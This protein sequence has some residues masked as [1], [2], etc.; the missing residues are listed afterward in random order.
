MHNEYNL[1]IRIT[2]DGFSLYLLE[3]N[4]KVL[5]SKKVEAPLFSLSTSEIENIFKQEK[6]IILSDYSQIQI[7]VE[8]NTYTTVPAALFI[9]SESD[10]YFHFEHADDKDKIVLFNRIPASDII[11]IFSLPLTLNKALT[12][13]FPETTPDH[14]IT[15]FL[16]E[17]IKERR[18]SIHVWIGKTSVDIILYKDNRINLINNYS[19]TSNEDIIYYILFLAET[20][21]FDTETAQFILYQD[22]NRKEVS[23]LLSAYVKNC[24][25]VSK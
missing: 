9:P 5:L 13:Q 16:K 18:D 8:T 10:H 11:N 6:D 19:V 1:S 3:Q 2:S 7:V 12:R 24:K 21:H 20:F 4:A 17:R 15:Y 25:T 22:D 23:D 14:H